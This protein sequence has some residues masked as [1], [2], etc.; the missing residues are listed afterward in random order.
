MTKGVE[1]EHGDWTYLMLR[2][3]RIDIYD[4]VTDTTALQ[5]PYMPRQGPS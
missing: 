5:P 1:L 2:T 3:N 4:C